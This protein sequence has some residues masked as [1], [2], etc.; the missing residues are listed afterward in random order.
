M[1]VEHCGA[2][3]SKQ[4]IVGL[5]CYIAKALPVK[6]QIITHRLWHVAT[7]LLSAKVLN[8]LEKIVMI[9]GNSLSWRVPYNVA[10]F[11]T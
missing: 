6:Y 4:Y 7:S 11:S 9:A 10:I 1:N 2:S 5:N 3:A 8:T